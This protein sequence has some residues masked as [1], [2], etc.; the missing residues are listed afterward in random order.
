MKRLC[1]AAI[2]LTTLL[3]LA[4]C[5]AVYYEPYE[6]PDP[7]PYSFTDTSKEV[8]PQTV[9]GAR[10]FVSD[11]RILWVY[12]NNSIVLSPSFC[13]TYFRGDCDDFAVMLAYY[14]QEYWLY[15]TYI[16]FN[17]DTRYREIGRAHV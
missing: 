7:Y 5:A 15:D 1:K 17:R 12:E 11:A 6:P 14:L 16:V 8:Y 13:A 9:S 3:L 2:L 10:R 4:G